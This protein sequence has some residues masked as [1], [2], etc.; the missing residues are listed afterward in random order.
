[1]NLYK[2]TIE[3]EIIRLRA[4]Y[5]MDYES[6]IVQHQHAF[7]QV[8][9]KDFDDK[10][11]RI[12]TAIV[13]ERLDEL[14]RIF[15]RMSGVYAILPTAP[16]PKTF[17]QKITN[18][19]SGKKSSPIFVGVGVLVV[20][21]EKVLL[22]RRRGSHCEDQVNLPGGHLEYGE[23]L[24]DAAAREVEQ[25]TGL[26]INLRMFDKNR[27]DWYV[28]NNILPVKDG[29]RHYLGVFLVG[30]YVSG[31]LVNKEPGKNYGYQWITYDTLLSHAKSKDAWL[32]KEFLET[33]RSKIGL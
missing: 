13:E 30:D 1:M 10:T 6:I 33:Y 4:T 29:E 15:N 7:P 3:R 31:E 26:K 11:R 23:D 12:Y 21:G 22:G 20:K 2:H 18:I 9:T 16:K 14:R 27:A 24:I 17:L 28:T 19:F 32:P 5:M 8:I 25:E